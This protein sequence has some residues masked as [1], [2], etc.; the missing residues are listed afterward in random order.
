M[1]KPY[2][3]TVTERYVM[4]DAPAMT[5]ARWRAP[6]AIAGEPH[7]GRFKEWASKT[8]FTPASDEQHDALTAALR[9]DGLAFEVTTTERYEPGQ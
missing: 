3:R 5:E 4:V 1:L 7:P 2:T 6:H 9:E 8:M